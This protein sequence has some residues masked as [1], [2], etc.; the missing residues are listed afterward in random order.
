M[1]VADFAVGVAVVWYKGRAITG[2]SSLDIVPVTGS[3]L[4]N[5][6]VCRLAVYCAAGFSRVCYSAVVTVSSLLF[7]D[8]F[9]GE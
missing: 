2:S 5:A 4:F 8:C 9:F 6:P 1:G 7:S 3:L